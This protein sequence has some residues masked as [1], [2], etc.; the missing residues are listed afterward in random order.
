MN[1]RCSSCRIP[2]FNEL[3]FFSTGFRQILEYQISWKSAQLEPSS[4]MRIDKT[5]IKKIKVTFFG[6]LFCYFEMARQKLRVLL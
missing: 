1:V 4:S 3:E 6:G 5:G 2:D